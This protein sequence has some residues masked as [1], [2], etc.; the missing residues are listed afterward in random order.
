LP[1]YGIV[2]PVWSLDMVPF[3]VLDKTGPRKR[4]TKRKTV[5]SIKTELP[6]KAIFIKKIYKN[7]LFT[8]FLV[9]VIPFK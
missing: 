9:V 4:P 2:I 1:F 8:Q 5:W 7:D 3:F 6:V